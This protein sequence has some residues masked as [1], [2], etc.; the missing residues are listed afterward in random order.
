MEPTAPQTAPAPGKPAPGKPADTNGKAVP[1][2]GANAITAALPSLAPKPR[3]KHPAQQI[4][5]ILADLRI[6]VVLFVLALILVFW[7][8]LAQVDTGVW[9][10]VHTYFRW[11]I[12]FVPMRVVF[13]NLIGPSTM[14]LPFPGGWTIGAAM[15]VNLLAAHAIRFKM[16]WARSGIFLIHAG[17]IVMML[18]EFITGLY[19]TEGQMII[20][21]GQTGNTVI[22]ARTSE[23]AI[24]RTIDAAKDDVVVVPARLL[25]PGAVVEDDRIPF[26]I[27]VADFMVNT[28]LH[29]AANQLA[30]KG[31]GRVHWAEK[32]AEVSGVDPKQ[33]ID[34][35]SAYLK[36]STREGKALGTWLF[37][38]KFADPQWLEIDGKKYQLSLRFKQTTRPFKL[39]LTNF[40]HKVFPGT[41][42]PKDFHSYI[43]LIDEKK[44][45][46]RPVEIYMN[47][48]LFYAGETFYQSSW[49]TDDRTGKANGT[50][51]QVVRNPGWLLPYLS[52][53]IVGVGML[54]HFGIMLQKFLGVRGFFIPIPGFGFLAFFSGKKGNV[55]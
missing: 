29:D 14:V 6:T 46:D 11:W 44:G 26:K 17:I 35:P 55:P 30:D 15:F 9:T 32:A 18:G 23:F 7:G 16:T 10:V 47:T 41:Q 36:L 28:K 45:I 50:I 40:E 49:L 5:E 2:V 39:Y 20:Q 27:E 43:R 22:D 19:Q 54:V 25:T 3:L 34:Y 48:P 52:C 42:T 12:A 53:G 37:S 38:T 8:T 24:V 33:T 51:L 4:V 13:F 1:P 21:I 31:F